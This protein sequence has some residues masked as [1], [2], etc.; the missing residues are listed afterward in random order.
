M[1]FSVLGE[2][3][4]YGTSADESDTDSFAKYTGESV[5][6]SLPTIFILSSPSHKKRVFKSQMVS[7]ILSKSNSSDVFLVFSN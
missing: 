7:N 4:S 6:R 5:P 2:L 1:I 3:W